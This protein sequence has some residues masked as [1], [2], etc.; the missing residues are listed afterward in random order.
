MHYVYHNSSG[1]GVVVYVLDTGVYIQHQAFEGRATWGNTFIPNE[2]NVDENGHGTHVAGTISSSLYGVT[3]NAKI[4]SVK[5]LGRC[6]DGT[7]SIVVDALQWVLADSRRLRDGGRHGQ[8]GFVVNMS[9]G[10]P[11]CRAV[12]DAVNRAVKA[13]LHVVVAAGNEDQDACD[14]SPAAAGQ[15]I[16]VGS[17]TEEDA[18]SEF[19]NHGGCVDVFAPGSDILSCGIDGQDSSTIKY[20]TSM[21]SPHV[22]GLVAYFLSIYPHPTFDPQLKSLEPYH[23]S[24]LDK[25]HQ[26]S[27]SFFA[28]ILTVASEVAL[29]HHLNKEKEHFGGGQS[30]TLTPGQM[31]NALLS[32]AL[33]D[34]ITGPLPSDTPNLLAYNNYRHRESS[35][36][37][38]EA[39]MV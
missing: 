32:R 31:K 3:K 9:I 24:S 22:A 15:V 8:K 38:D 27:P 19:S 6:G 1:D 12:D 11:R 34:R 37:D 10:G 33:S 14:T 26:M 28:S 18:R 39:F 30:N 20:G 16:T 2:G 23:K 36:W 21:A 35:I 5:V 25:A 7:M 4:R 13:G 29:N 17:T